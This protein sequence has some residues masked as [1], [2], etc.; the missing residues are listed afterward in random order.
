M[1]QGT[2]RERAIPICV[3]STGLKMNDEEVQKL[4]NKSTTKTEDHYVKSGV[5]N[6]WRNN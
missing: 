4:I 5:G 6:F 2:P 3:K 1:A